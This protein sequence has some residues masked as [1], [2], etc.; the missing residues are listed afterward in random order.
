MIARINR[1]RTTAT[2]IPAMTPGARPLEVE[3]SV[4]P[5]VAVLPAKAAGDELSELV[6]V[7]GGGSG[8]VLPFPVP[9][10][11]ETLV[12]VPVGEVVGDE[13]GVFDVVVPWEVPWEVE[14]DVVV[15]GESEAEQ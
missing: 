1:A 10:V 9:P 7:D 15:V 6:V 5:L 12:E 3:R 8:V 2:T 4:T 11:V 14:V 13:V